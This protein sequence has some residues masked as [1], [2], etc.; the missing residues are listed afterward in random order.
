MSSG[1]TCSHQKGSECDL[2]NKPCVLYGKAVFSNP[3]NPSNDAIE[4]REKRQK[5]KR[6]R[7]AMDAARFF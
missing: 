1:W 3:E 2:L 4:R 5:E 7:E 6:L